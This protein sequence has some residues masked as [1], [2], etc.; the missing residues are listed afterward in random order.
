MS[1]VSANMAG[2]PHNSTRSRPMSLY[3]TPPLELPEEPDLDSSNTKELQNLNNQ[4]FTYRLLTFSVNLPSSVNSTS[5][6]APSTT[7]TTT[8]NNNNKNNNINNNINNNTTTTTTKS[9]TRN[10]KEPQRQP[11]TNNSPLKTGLRTPMANGASFSQTP[12]APPSPKTP[13]NEIFISTCK[14]PMFE[15]KTPQ[16]DF[17]KTPTKRMSLPPN[18]LEPHS[19]FLKQQ[20]ESLLEEKPNI[21]S[22]SRIFKRLSGMFGRHTTKSLPTG[23][24]LTDLGKENDLKKHYGGEL[25]QQPQTNRTV[26]KTQKFQ[27]TP[28]TLPTHT[29]VFPALNRFDTLSEKQI[30]TLSLSSKTSSLSPQNNIFQNTPQSSYPPSNNNSDLIDVSKIDINDSTFTVYDT[31][32]DSFDTSIP[33]RSPARPCPTTLSTPKR[34]KST[35]SSIRNKSSEKRYSSVDGYLSVPEVK[36][37]SPGQY[38][39]DVVM[40]IPE[41]NPSSKPSVVAP[42]RSSTLRS[43]SNIASTTSNTSNISNTSTTGNTSNTNFNTTPT[44]SRSNSK[45]ASN[46]HLI[47]GPPS[48]YP[49]SHLVHSTPASEADSILKLNIYLQEYNTPLQLQL[50]LQLPLQLQLLLILLLDGK[51]LNQ[52]ANFIA[53]KLRKDKLRNINE[54]INVILFK[55]MT[56][57]QD[58]NVND[59]KLSIFFRDPALKPI[60][61]KDC[62]GGHRPNSI[63]AASPT[64][65]KSPISIYTPTLSEGEKNAFGQAQEIYINSDALLLDYVQLKRKLYIKAQF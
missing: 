31:T 16:T 56:K 17:K 25:Q 1:T 23:K 24:Q 45:K 28:T 36:V 29:F 44:R 38:P 52:S 43:H 3:T 10:I 5:P 64:K 12:S 41:P 61:L 40:P 58:I 21:K 65:T 20:N 63:A 47:A 60:V 53:I 35:N 7:T 9:A 49:S 37:S 51:Q 26:Y 14:E 48:A 32:I 18:Y 8:N 27:T 57:R 22:P 30:K 50:Q 6:T 54:L 4:K 33:I 34:E 59:V 19:P 42:R 11:S 55:I 62:I 2:K 13:T 39:N 46:R 15:L